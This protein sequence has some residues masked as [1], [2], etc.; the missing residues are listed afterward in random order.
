MNGNNSELPPLEEPC[1]GCGGSGDAP[2]GNGYEM[3]GSFNCPKC[4]GHKLAPT[5]AG[6]TL[7]DFVKRRLSLSE[8]EATRS[9]FG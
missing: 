6:R 8:P 4:K 5:A 3:R 2:S 7:L 9:L 1:D